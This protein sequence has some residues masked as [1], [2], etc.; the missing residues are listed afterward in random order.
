MK[1]IIFLIAVAL[2]GKV[3]SQV[4]T[5]SGNALD[6][7][8]NIANANHVNLGPLTSINNADFSFECWMKV[9]S[10]NADPP[11]FSNKDWG[12]GTNTGMAFDVQGS[13]TVM[14]FNFKGASNTRQDLTVA[15]NE[16]RRDWFHFA[17][18]YKK[19]GYFKVYINGV[20]KD[21]L[22]VSSITSSFAST[23][24]YKLGQDGTGN[25]TDAG[26][27]PRFNGKMDE[28]RI[29]TAVRT[30]QE[31]RDNMCHKLTGSETNLYAYY[32]CDVASGTTLPD[33]STG[34]VNTGTLVNSIAANWSTS[35]APIG[36]SSVNKY[37]TVYG[38]NTLQ[39]SS[40]T[41]GVFTVKNI[42]STPGIH[43]YNVSAQPNYTVGLSNLP[44]NANYYGV[45]VADTNNTA[46][47]DVE[48][49]YTNFAAATS[50]EPNLKLFNR[51][52]N[53]AMYWS[54]Y[55]ATQNA[56]ANTLSKSL[57]NL[58]KEFITGT[59]TGV[60]CN[61]PTA[62]SL[63][64]SGV[65]TAT[66]SWTTGGATTWNVQWG[67]QGFALGTGTAIVNS[68]T[69]PAV[70]SGLAGNRFYDM[71]VQDTCTG[72]GKSY[73]VGPVTFNTGVCVVPTVLT[74]TNVTHNAATLSW[75]A[76][77]TATFD[78][79]WGL[80]G[81]TS[82][83]GT[84]VSGV[85]N[86]YTLTGLGPNTAYSYQVRSVCGVGNK[87]A[88]NGPFSFTTTAAPANTTFTTGPGNTL[89]FAPNIANANHVNLGPLTNINNGDF[90][91]ECWMKVNSVTNDPAFFSNKSWASGS[92]TGLV[93]DVE[94]N[95]AVMKFNFKDASNA[96]KD[97]TVAVNEHRRDWF[98][99]AG[100][101]KKGGYF[102]V[103]ING[104]A[105][106][107]LDVSSITGSFA[108]TY[109]YKL[110]QDG[111][112]N[113]SYSG[114]NPRFNGK[115]DEVRIWTDVRTQ[116][117][118][119]DNMCHKLAGSETNLY[120]YYN[121]DVTSGTVLPDLS[122]GAVNTGT[123]VNSISANWTTSGAPIG[124]RSVNK[125]ST[126]YGT[127]TLQITNPAYGDFTVKNIASTPGIHLYNV[128]AQPNYTVGLNN[129]PSNANYYGVFVTDTNST[130]SYDVEY[131]YT[132]F[133]AAISDE[134]NL[135]L[136][137]R[138]KNDAMYWSDYA[139]TQNATANTL[140]KSL[141]NMRRE[142]ITGTK[143]GLTCNAPT[144]VSL[145]GSGV[146]TATV[147][148]TT[149]GATTWNVQWGPQGFALGTGTAIV[150]SGTNP[151]VFSG[152]I[153]NRFYDMYVQDTCTGSGKSYWVGPTVFNA[154]IC[155]M[156][157]VLTA[158]NVTHNAATLSW[159]A[160]S[161]AT[162]DIEW[163]LPGFTL[164]TGIQVSNV[165]NPYTLT[166]LGPNTVYSYQVRSV[167]GGSNKSGYNGPYN[168]TTTATPTNTTPA[169][170]IVE[171]DLS[172][173]VSVY[174]NPSNG[175]VTVS[176][177]Q[178][179]ENAAI[180]VTDVLGKTLME[181]R[182]ADS[183]SLSKTIDLKAYGRGIYFIAVKNGTRQTVRKVIVN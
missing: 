57:L 108:S 98:H 147:S 115:I 10:V 64:G 61:A 25:Y 103:Y 81:F 133:A 35:G 77:S 126:A 14:K 135:K 91:F 142:F 163:G 66:V 18:T 121:C 104:I 176:I 3:V 29:W 102:K 22:N 60:T 164:G 63:S 132:N 141:L 166:G 138:V 48:Y 54:D 71:Y 158:T 26:T 37:A 65:T 15:V 139:A 100:T 55:A 92:N 159:N 160:A 145:T 112:G 32:N 179:T 134:P 157:T 180:I 85:T 4:T 28:V 24:T 107:S 88:Y 52:K 111:T 50:D 162:F 127:S 7:A 151:A 165:T 146:S 90:S 182:L 125:Y 110:G 72:S 56:T 150:N 137:N 79:E 183:A 46:S 119:R 87:S 39:I 93:F 94:D 131:N 168:F 89:D 68:G 45:F 2:T 36:N 41:Y 101:Y 154:A 172:Q 12:S 178:K 58:R 97:L 51:V 124:D 113:Y 106:D 175:M 70:F 42:A 13:G 33:L 69:N 80:P 9:N 129:L 174:P 47:Y 136:F 177:S 109:T 95:G 59:K 82:G 19:G 62:V 128:S 181:E 116:H 49:D 21:S 123:L 148:W 53:D 156:P 11:F 167:C 31:I 171:N 17:G 140:S 67:P 118:I 40:A 74:A 86:P 16:H 114:N 155:V 20:A 169:T 153:S 78:I 1:K 122:T 96:R 117:E 6:F 44:S 161:T 43:L 170:G 84:Q 120:A 149:G 83:T 38:T 30:Q 8:A 75:N 23:Y 152:L 27:H 143:T 105:K 173:A 130:A 73:W 34:A 76:A 99:F 5:G 144:A